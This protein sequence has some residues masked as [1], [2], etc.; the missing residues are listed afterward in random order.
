MTAPDTDPDADDAPVICGFDGEPSEDG[1]TLIIRATA[2]DGSVVPFAIP[3]DDVKHFIAFLLAWVGTIGAGGDSPAT[4]GRD[5][6]VGAGITPIPADSIA[7][8]QPSGQEGYIGISVGRA[9]LV[10]ALPLASFGPLGRTLLMA[11]T[12]ANRTPA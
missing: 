6:A 10:F 2:A 1:E 9:E 4:E 8:G 11:G 7:I 12:P 3:I 5:D